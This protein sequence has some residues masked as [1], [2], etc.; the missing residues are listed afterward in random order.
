MAY[1][2]LAQAHANAGL[3]ITKAYVAVAQAFKYRDRLTTPERYAT[4][5]TY[6]EYVGDFDRAAASYQ[7]LLDAYPMSEVARHN[8]GNIPYRRKDWSAAEAQYREFAEAYPGILL[9]YT[10]PLTAQVNQGKLKG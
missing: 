5:G 2:K 9:A 1:R 7:A 4:E 10:S 3:G 6:W 8:L